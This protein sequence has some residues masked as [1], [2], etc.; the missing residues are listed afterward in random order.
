MRSE[1]LDS[2]CEQLAD[3]GWSGGARVGMEPVSG[4]IHD[5]HRLRFER[6]DIF[7]KTSRVEHAVMLDDEADALQRLRAAAVVLLPEPLLCGI[8]GESAYLALEWLDLKSASPDAQAR[9]ARMLAALHAN[10]ADR[11]GWHRDNHIGLTRQRNAWCDDWC[12]FFATRRLEYQLRLAERD[13]KPWTMEGF[14]L[15]ER[16]P[17]LLEGHKPAASLLHGD[18]WNGNMAMRSDGEPVVYDPAS[19][20]GDR[21]TDIAMT[22]LFGGFSP[23]FYSAYEAEWPLD[24]GYARRRPLYQLYHII[25]HANMFGGGYE[26]QAAG[27]IN[28]LLSGI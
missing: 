20:Y 7:L 21:E 16:L 12:E 1:D 23:A 11:H 25:N 2:L 15:I 10:E 19:Y 27:M 26:R 14:R 18:L 8:A 28:T 22:E 9:L 17:L 6:A 24:D 4:G 5:A 3:A 13:G